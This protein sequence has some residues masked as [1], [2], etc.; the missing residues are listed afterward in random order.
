MLQYLSPRQGDDNPFIHTHS[1]IPSDIDIED[2]VIVARC[3]TERKGIDELLDGML[4]LSHNLQHINSTSLPKYRL[5]VF[6]AGQ[7]EK[8]KSDRVNY[9]HKFLASNPFIRITSNSYNAF[10]YQ[11][12]LHKA[13][14][15]IMLSKLE[16]SSIAAL[17]ALWHGIPCV[18]TK[19]CGVDGFL[20]NIHGYLLKDR[21]GKELA[22]VIS[23]LLSND[24][25]LLD[26]WRLNLFHY[27]E[28]FSWNSYILSLDEILKRHYMLK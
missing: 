19:G 4:E 23:R 18:L 28:S 13:H 17:E 21:S 7:L 5:N 15:F 2:L 11:Q 16:S 12:M 22:S 9:V 26:L 10:E 20:H 3:N 1:Q 24:R 14:L 27:R 25:P 8:N 6:I